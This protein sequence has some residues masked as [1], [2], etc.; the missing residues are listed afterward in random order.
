MCPNGEDGNFLDDQQTVNPCVNYLINHWNQTIKK[1]PVLSNALYEAVKCAVLAEGKENIETRTEAIKKAIN[2]YQTIL[3]DDDY[4][5]VG[6]TSLYKFISNR[7]DLCL[8]RFINADKAYQ[9]FAVK[10]LNNM[11]SD[12]PSNRTKELKI[13]GVFGPDNEG[14]RLISTSW[15]TFRMKE[16]P[17]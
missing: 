5:P 1:E 7:G 13:A 8:D 12:E 9:E 2:T 16:V 4:W 11:Q 14:Y 10:R 6:R 15:G 17:D 3:G